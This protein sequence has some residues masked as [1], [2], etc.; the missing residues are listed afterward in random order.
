MRRLL[1]VAL[2][3]AFVVMVTSAKASSR[4]LADSRATKASTSA[5][6]A[7]LAIHQEA[8]LLLEASPSQLMLTSLKR[9]SLC[10]APTCD[11][12]SADSAQN[13]A[14]KGQVDESQLRIAY[15]PQFHE[16]PS[17]S[18]EDAAPSVA[19]SANFPFEMSP[20]QR[21]MANNLY[22]AYGDYWNHIR[23]VRGWAQP[24]FPREVVDDGLREAAEIA[25]R[26][27][28]LLDAR[29]PGQLK[30]RLRGGS[31]REYIGRQ[32]S[33]PRERRAFVD[34]VVHATFQ[35]ESGNY[36]ESSESEIIE[37]IQEIRSLGV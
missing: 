3:I 1:R 12:A 22:G 18:G 7:S 13:D 17:S 5:S 16:K 2:L 4:Q 19:G 29:S 15:T 32:P 28:S 14:R 36:R 34:G 31:A 11:A 35:D 6:S 20:E 27:Q 10:D 23:F 26:I 37:L 9:K 8:P 25:A 21:T 30:L 33:V 24:A